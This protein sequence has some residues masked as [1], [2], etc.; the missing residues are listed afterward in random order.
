MICIIR[1]SIYT[2]CGLLSLVTLSE[3]AQAQTCTT[4]QAG[5][6]SSA[7]TWSCT[8]GA[9][10]PPGASFTGTIVINKAINFDQ[11]LTISG[12]T[13]I[14]VNSGGSINFGNNQVLTLSNQQSTINLAA[15]TSI[16]GGSA[17]SLIKIGTSPQYTF[18]P[19]N[20]HGSIS[21]PTILTSSGL[22]VNLVSFTAKPQGEHVQINWEITWEQNADAFEIQRSQ[23]LGE[24]ITVGQLAAKGN[25]DQRQYYG[26]T[27]QWPLEGISYYRLKQI[28]QD[29]QTALSKVQSVVMDELTPSFELL[30]NPNNGQSI[31]VAVRNLAGATYQLTT[32]TGRELAITINYLPNA[33]LIIMP[34]QPLSSGIYV[35]R[36]VANGKQLAQKIVV[37]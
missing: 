23:D 10:P 13:T 2:L 6:W 9:T 30:E 15:G 27:D 19:F 28:D 8:G 17:N 34:V 21:G 4:V 14:N 29:G 26:F 31:Q 1:Q 7:A 36:A 5:N 32:L 12:Q 11:T 33:T 37:R 3:M 24:F 16:F 22:P 20:G 35:L 18:G 25:T